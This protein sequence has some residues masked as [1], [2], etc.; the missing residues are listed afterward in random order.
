MNSFVFER[1]EELASFS[2]GDLISSYP[3]LSTHIGQLRDIKSL[4]EWRASQVLPGMPTMAVT[5]RRCVFE[6]VLMA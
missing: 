4:N 1:V 2:A 6:D 3:H 5:G